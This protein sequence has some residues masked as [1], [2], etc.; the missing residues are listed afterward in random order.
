MDVLIVFYELK[1]WSTAVAQP[2]GT[3]SILNAQ[4]FWMP[5]E[6]NTLWCFSE[7]SWLVFH[8]QR[9]GRTDGQTDGQTDGRYQT[10]Y[11]PCFAVDNEKISAHPKEQWADHQISHLPADPQDIHWS[12]RL[13]KRDPFMHCP[14]GPLYCND[15]IIMLSCMWVKVI[16][17][18]L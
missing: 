17:F 10:Y 18:W 12:S 8:W 14:F 1:A 3:T 2:V 13:Y 15:Q 9:N 4:P 7:C 16:F 11:L 5:L 6:I